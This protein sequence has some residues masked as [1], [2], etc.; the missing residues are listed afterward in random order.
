MDKE[1][2]KDFAKNIDDF[3]KKFKGLPLDNIQIR[4]PSTWGGVLHGT[5]K[6]EYKKL[7]KNY[8]PCSYIWSSMHF[9]WD[10][11]V[12]ACTTDFWGK[13]TLGKFPDQSIKEIWNGEKFQNFR[14]AMIEKKYYNHFEYCDKCDSLWSECILGLPPGIRGVSAFVISNIFGFTSI[15][16]LKRMA[17]KINSRF[18]MRSIK[19]E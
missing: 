3:K 14:K 4:Q 12:V 16:I 18:V 5:D 10:G 13:N 6:Y 19:K 11:S 15:K 7:G 9:L 2:Q 1:G 17:E 8:S